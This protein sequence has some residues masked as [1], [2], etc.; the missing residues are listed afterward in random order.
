[1]RSWKSVC[2]WIALFL[3]PLFAIAQDAATQVSVSNGAAY[4]T[5]SSKTVVLANVPQVSGTLAPAVKRPPIHPLGLP[6]DVLAARKAESA[7]GFGSAGT[8]APLITRGIYT[9]GTTISYEGIGQNGWTPSDMGLAVAPARIVQAVNEQITLMTK[10]GVVIS[11]YPKPLGPMFGLAADANVFDPRLQYDWAN[12]RYILIALYETP[13][14]GNAS[15][16]GY[17]CLAVSATADPGGAWYSYLLPVGNVGEFPDF[18][19]M[20]QDHTSWPG[21]ATGGIYVGL[22]NFSATT[23]AFLG[24]FVFLIPKSKVYA[25]LGFSYWAFTGFGID[26]TLV[27]TLQPV[28]VM[29]RTDHPRAVFFV[30]SKNIN[31]NC[32]SGTPCNGLVVWAISNPFGYIASGPSPEVSGVVVSTAHNYWIPPNA[33]QPSCSNCIDTADNRITGGITYSAGSIFGSFETADPGSSGQAGPIW[34]ELHPT[35]NDNETGGRCTGAYLNRCPWV[36]DVERRQEDCYLCGAW[37]DSGMAYYATLQPD[38]ENNLLMVFNFSSTATYPG[39]AYVTRRVTQAPNVMHDAGI[40]LRSG[41]AAYTQTRWGDYTGTAPDFSSLTV[42]FM[43]FS[44]MYVKGDG[45]W[46][47]S[48]GAVRYFNPG[49][50]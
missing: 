40:M 7:A 44:G 43:Y 2:C 42:P 48:I 31:F 20:G 33:N 6:P 28:N 15:N 49:A 37:A 11:G 17:L 25:G 38:P 27:D 23:G 5:M 30:N 19:S 22:N 3:L 8:A 29:N 45:Q 18:P 1:M 13:G 10:A 41:L 26:S 50:P 47:T 46:G 12:N 21:E 9:T 36:T 14:F 24:N 32:T 35:L 34:F 16:Q 4:T 39:T